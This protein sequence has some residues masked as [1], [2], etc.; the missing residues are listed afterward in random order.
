MAMQP[1]LSLDVGDASLLLDTAAPLHAAADAPVVAA[2][3]LPRPAEQARPPETPVFRPGQGGRTFD[4]AG[5]VPAVFYN[6]GANETPDREGT[7]G[8]SPAG[9][10]KPPKPWSGGAEDWERGLE[11]L[12]V[13]RCGVCGMKSP[14]DVR[15][16][17]Q[18]CIECEMS[19]P[20]QRTRGSVN[21][22][23]AR[24]LYPLAASTKNMAFAPV[25]RSVS[26]GDADLLAQIGGWMSID[27]PP[28]GS[29]T[30][31]VQVPLQI[32]E[33]PGRSSG[34]PS[35]WGTPQQHS[36]HSLWH[37]QV[38]QTTAPTAQS[39]WQLPQSVPM[40]GGAAAP[41]VAMA[42][43]TQVVELPMAAVAMPVNQAAP[44]MAKAVP[45]M[46]QA[47]PI[48]Q[49]TPQRPRDRGGNLQGRLATSQA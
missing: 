7:E 15:A 44:S 28:S 24:R 45:V 38:P 46:A 4:W 41:Q 36:Y 42:V 5:A 3:L 48:P 19:Q 27:T 47:V 37:P 16:I 39:A 18:H 49:Q 12:G 2:P 30:P 25:P 23:V 14:L 17:E 31:G 8:G 20:L 40:P 11:A 32:P 43:A 26:C 9:Q 10:R 34:A 6:L 21:G 29:P 1:S 13:A 35:P 33:S 22:P